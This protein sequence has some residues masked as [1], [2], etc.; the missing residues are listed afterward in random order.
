MTRRFATALL[1]L[2]TWFVI[3]PPMATAHEGHVHKILGTVT[4][5]APDH[6]MLKDKNGKDVTVHVTDKTRIRQDG[7]PAGSDAIKNGMRV[8]VGA[9][10]VKEQGADKLMAQTIDLG[11]ATAK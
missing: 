1:A 6:V 10:T 8:V 3:A 5:A 9:L 4:M 7:K 11:P 2:F